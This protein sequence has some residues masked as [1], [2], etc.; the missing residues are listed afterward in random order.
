MYA[1][2]MAG[3]RG[4]R[5]WPRS[6]K[7]SPKQLLNIIGEKTI[8]EQT[9]DR[10]RPLCPWDRIYI[11]TEKDQAPLIRDLL[12]DLPG[13]HLI[14]EP[15]GKNTAP[16]IGLAARLLA[17]RDPAAVMAIL[18]ADHYIA[19]ESDFRHVLAAAGE[20]A[21]A[22][23]YLITLG[24]TPTFPETG[25]GYI[26]KGAARAV[27][28]DRP[29][30][31]V[32]AFHEKPDR[33]KAEAM[34]AAGGFFWNSGMFIWTAAAIL[35]KMAQYTPD[36]FR[37]IQGLPPAICHPEWEP[38]LLAAYE[39][40]E[41]ISI[42]YAVME[43]AD[44]VLM[45]EGDFGWNDVGS[46]EAVYQ[47]EARDGQGNCF[48]GPVV[49]LDSTGCLV[50]SPRKLVALLGVQNLVVVETPDALLICP[51]ERSQEV[52]KIVELL[53]KKGDPSLL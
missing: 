52:K 13:D 2:I 39:R 17:E 6:R 11:V 36:L 27:L 4:T 49:T 8:L 19:R 37:E 24:I 25:Y 20:A 51:R 5:F 1:V 34:L 12:P 47:L 35:K 30:W 29:V 45:L 38:A 53:E 43:K 7:K 41:D 26:E 31:A 16:C 21:R 14:V 44:N 33:P 42:D 22:G 18:P 32:K 9:V 40:M 10:I 23:D 3:G 28:P 46:W 50:Y 48:Q 15:L